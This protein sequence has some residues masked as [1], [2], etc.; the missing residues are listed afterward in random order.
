MDLHIG[1][2]WLARIGDAV[3]IEI[4]PDEITNG[5]SEDGCRVGSNIV[6]QIR[7]DAVATVV[8]D[9][10]RVV[11]RRSAG[12]ERKIDRDRVTDRRAVAGRQKA[13]RER[14]TGWIPADA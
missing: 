4:E 7:I 13:D 8:G 12:G 6:A 9:S 1:K 14:S 11:N 2:S 3:G 10:R 5:R